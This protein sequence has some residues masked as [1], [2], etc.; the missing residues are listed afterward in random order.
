M[1]TSIS[2]VIP[3]FNSGPVLERAI[4][5]LIAQ[6]YPNLQIILIDAG[7]TDASREIIERYRHLFDTVIIEKDRGQADAINKGF[8]YARGEILGWLCADDEL[9][10][11]A[12]RQ[13]A[14]KFAADP[15]IDVV[16]GGCER[17]FAD[18]ARTLVPADPNA[19]QIVNVQN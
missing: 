19:W 4:Q 5:S 15:S 12:L 8:S 17:V 16:T 2:I 3:N 6:Q 1:P 14:E 18:G 11:N 13:I 10:S 9:L 7:S